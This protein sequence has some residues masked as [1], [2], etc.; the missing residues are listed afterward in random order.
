MPPI[1]ID[2]SAVAAALFKDEDP[3]FA[4]AALRYV[5]AHGGYV[6]SLFW[7]E[8]RNIL[9]IG[10]RRGRITKDQ[11]SDA[12]DMLRLSSLQTPFEPDDVSVL[13]MARAHT[14]SGYDGAYAVLAAREKAPFATLDKKLIAAG[15]AGAFDLWQPADETPA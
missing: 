11:S 2:A 15:A 3:T 10:E 14:L 1:V 6:P 5:G 4:A 12:M 7:H 9:I 8:V 13:A